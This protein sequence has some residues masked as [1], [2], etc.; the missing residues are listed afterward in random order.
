MGA[1]FC[2]PHLLFLDKPF[3]DQLIDGRFHKPGRDFLPV[4]IAI[5]IIGD[6][7]VVGLDVAR[8]ILHCLGEFGKWAP[9]LS[10]PPPN[11]PASARFCGHCHARVL[12]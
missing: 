8:E 10:A 3:S 7:G 2:P 12:I 4:S 5:T 9:T 11:L 6:E 1:F